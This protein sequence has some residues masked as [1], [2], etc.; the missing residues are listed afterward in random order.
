MK[1]QHSLQRSLG[2]FTVTLY[3]VG[4]ILGAGIYVLIGEVADLA[5]YGAPVSF[6]VAAVIAIFSAFSYAELSARFPKSAG[7]AVY[8]DEAFNCRPLTMTIGLLVILTG[9]V[10]AAT[11]TTGVVGYAQIFVDLPSSILISFFVVAI[12]AV[13]IW[14]IKQSAWVVTIITVLE[15]CG[16]VYV[17]YVASDGLDSLAVTSFPIG[18]SMDSSVATGILLGSFLAFYA[19]IG[20]EDMVNI[21]EEIK[22]PEKVLPAAIVLALV[23]A[24]LL[25]MLV[26]Y[27]ALSVLSPEQ[28]S[29]SNAPLADVVIS[30]GYSGSWI[31]IVSLVA[32]INGAIIQIIMAS[33][34]VYGMASRQLLPSWLFSVN[35]VTLTPIP[36]TL[37]SAFVVL[38]LALVFPLSTLAQLT[39]LIVLSVFVLVNIALI[40]LN[41]GVTSAVGKDIERGN[42]TIHF[43]QWVPYMAAFL[44]ICMLLVK[45]VFWLSL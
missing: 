43:P 29:A 40:K 11:M 4:A 33:R 16:L 15:V 45:M 34:V 14:G 3:G 2:F 1:Q 37:L 41:R 35:S 26:A 21:A 6:I 25:Y 8:I 24:T 28:L 5:G 31:S 18:K 10:S 7:E 13:A 19:Y 27:A 32:V 12:S 39:S 44:C 30:K 17:V 22:N 38:T 9:I 23:I 42:R 36:A 20:F